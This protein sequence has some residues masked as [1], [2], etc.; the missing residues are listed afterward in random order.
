VPLNLVCD[1][2]AEMF[3]IQLKN[4]LSLP[5]TATSYTER[6]MQYLQTQRCSPDWR[7]D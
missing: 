5:I 3:S 6:A 1:S 2:N 4:T 7:C